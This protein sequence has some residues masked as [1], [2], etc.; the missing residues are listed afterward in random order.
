MGK[1]NFHLIKGNKKEKNGKVEKLKKAALVLAVAILILVIVRHLSTWVYARGASF[2]VNTYLVEETLIDK[3]FSREGLIIRQEDIISAPYGGYLLWSVEEGDRVGAGRVVAEIMEEISSEE[4]EEGKIEVDEAE[5]VEE[6][7]VDEAEEEGEIEEAQEDG[8]AEEVPEE[9]E[10]LAERLDREKVEEKT[11]SLLNVIRENMV[12]GNMGEARDYY[13]QL[14]GYSQEVMVRRSFVRGKREIITPFSG[15]AVFQRDGLEE[16]LTPDNIDFLSFEQMQ[17]FEPNIRKIKS[18]EKVE[19]GVPLVKIVDNYAWFFTA[20]L[21]PSQRDKLNNR[22]WVNLDFDFAPGDRV[23]ARVYALEEDEEGRHLATFR[24]TEHL[25][26][27]YLHRQVKARINYE[28]FRGVTIPESA[29]IYKGEKR[30]VYSVEKAMVRFRQVE[31]I[32]ALGEEVLVEELSPGRLIIT[33]PSYFRE[34]QYIHG[35][36][37]ER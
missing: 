29:L 24:V 33:N 1:N 4:S 7:E 15:I 35:L 31:V 30:G 23:R 27:F 36:G 9:K 22:D 3:S 2:F 18:G 12:K 13:Q 14:K 17:D 28:S 11:E 16:I 26:E 8:E 20:Y 10:E 5:E 21:N 37:E 34:G 6:I 25:E 19:Q 32:D